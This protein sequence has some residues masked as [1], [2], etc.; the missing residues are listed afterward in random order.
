MKR[1]FK[2][3][4]VLILLII[5]AAGG[6]A[7]YVAITGVPRYAHTAPDLKVEVTPARVERGKTIANMLC[8]ECHLD[9]KTNRLTGH[10]MEDLPA[11]LGVAFSKNLTH[12]KN[13]GIGGWTD[14]ELAYLLRT[15]VRRDG[16]YTPP[17]MPK[18][19]RMQE[20]DLLSII[21]F[22]RS[23]DS[24]VMADPTPDRESQ[25]SFLAKFLTHVAFKPF[26]YPAA[27]VLA[28]DTAD[29]VAFGR[30]LSQDAFDCFPCHSGDFKK[31][32]LDHPEKSFRFYGGGNSMPDLTGRLINTANLTPDAET[33]IG[34]WSE[35]DFV[36]AVREGVRP[37]GRLLRYPMARMPEFTEDE[38]KAIFAY[39][40]TIP[41]IK[42]EVA[43]N[44]ES[45]EGPALTD[46]KALFAKYGCVVCH[47]NQGVGIGDVTKAKA[48]FP[49]DSSLQAWIRNPSA[50]KPLT[51]MP[52]FQGVIKEE[53]YAPLIAYVRELGK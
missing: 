48:D 32:D 41:A 13:V 46:G 10:R 52:S 16:L 15:G 11:E 50:F 45:L 39:L 29:K 8:S 30:Y 22:L 27:P 37:D 17:W 33:G 1:F 34:K 43:R 20:E 38:A 44:F 35:A 36:K 23:D 47:A 3:L 53:E 19:P 21:A 28:P 26:P 9:V 2:I 14:G 4:G 49:A 5:L 25:P 42:Y 6:F 31:M 7:A 18:L 24:L 51:K 12:D 40:K